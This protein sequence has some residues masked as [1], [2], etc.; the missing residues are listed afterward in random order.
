VLGLY[1]QIK[2]SL[3]WPKYSLVKY[4]LVKWITI[5]LD[6]LCLIAISNDDISHHTSSVIKIKIKHCLKKHLMIGWEIT[7]H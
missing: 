5:W 6:Y 4:G 1:F 3:G 2:V 7:L